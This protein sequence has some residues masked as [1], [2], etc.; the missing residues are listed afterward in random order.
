MVGNISGFAASIWMRRIRFRAEFQTAL[1][2][3]DS[4]GRRERPVS[5]SRPEKPDR[6]L[7]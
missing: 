5:I 4:S 1:A 7:A 3:A 2:Q 6:L